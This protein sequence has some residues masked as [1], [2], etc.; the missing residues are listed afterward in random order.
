MPEANTIS[1]YTVGGSRC[2]G[3][4]WG[5]ACEQSLGGD[6]ETETWRKT[7][8]QESSRHLLALGEMSHAGGRSVDPRCVA[9]SA[10]PTFMAVTDRM[11][12]SA[13]RSLTAGA[14]PLGLWR[15]RAWHEPVLPANESQARRSA[16]ELFLAGG[17]GRLQEAEACLRT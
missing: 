9:R 12:R 4:G 13:G 2:Q 3:S 10:P 16:S 5:F 6:G 14:T 17:A 15:S 11:Q 1:F 8:Q 7:I